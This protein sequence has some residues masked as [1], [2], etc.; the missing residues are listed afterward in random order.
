MEA[1][2]L[3]LILVVGGIYF[4]FRNVRL[5]RNEAALREYMQ[6]SPKA[7]LWVRKYGL[8]GATKM[9][10]E[11]FIPLGLVISTAMVA[12]GGWNLWRMYL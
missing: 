5:L 11:S 9:V 6:S 8:D 1:L 7:T 4:G 3:S 12:F 2:I 10:R